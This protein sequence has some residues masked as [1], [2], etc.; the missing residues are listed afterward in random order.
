MEK[1]Y[2]VYYMNNED[3][4]IDKTQIDEFSEELALDMYKEFGHDVS[5][6]EYMAVLILQDDDPETRGDVDDSDLEKHRIAVATDADKRIPTMLIDEECANCGKP[7][8]LEIGD[9]IFA[10]HGNLFCGPECMD[11]HEEH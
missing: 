4:I 7:L 6:L 9:T 2:D 1:V 11:E 5:K 8:E 3:E 10:R